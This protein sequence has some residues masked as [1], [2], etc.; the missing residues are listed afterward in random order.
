MVMPDRTIRQFNFVMEAKSVI[1]FPSSGHKLKEPGFC[2]ISGLAWSGPARSRASRC[3]PMMVDL[4]RG[5]SAR[6]DHDEMPD[7]VSA[8]LAL[9]RRRSGAREPGGPTIPAM[10]S[11]AAKPC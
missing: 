10:F 8:A 5:G 4:A 6:T 2:E 3:R 9:G 11:R 1:T 7:A